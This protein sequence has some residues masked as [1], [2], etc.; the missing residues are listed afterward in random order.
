MTMIPVYIFLN[1]CFYYYSVNHAFWKTYC[2]IIFYLSSIL[3]YHTFAATLMMQCGMIDLCHPLCLYSQEF[4]E[5][6]NQQTVHAFYY[7]P[8]GS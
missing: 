1:L 5:I 7:I 4:N 3:I 6:G 8:V 2:K